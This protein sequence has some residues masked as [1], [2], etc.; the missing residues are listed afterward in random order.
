MNKFKKVLKK[1]SVLTTVAVM[2]V[3]AIN[4]IVASASNIYKINSFTGYP[5]E[6]SLWCW[7]ACA[8]TSGKHL[9][10]N[11]RTQRNTVTVVKGSPINE[12]GSVTE[13]AMAANYFTLNQYNYNGYNFVYPIDFL[14][15][16]IINNSMPILGASSYNSSGVRT[17]S[18]ATV[19]YMVTYN[20]D[21]TRGIGYYD[22]DTGSY[23][24]GDKKGRNYICSFEKFCN[25][26]YNGRIY[27][28]TTY[29]N[30]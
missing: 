15:G 4:S 10:N 21:G 22:P 3:Y 28:R 24:P 27:E 13:T 5:Q 1:L 2:Y 12:G 6:M 19:A 9:V 14:K 25:G 17:S 20:D 11:I 7:V 23:P 26:E 18:H 30:T 29:T 16:L 8:E